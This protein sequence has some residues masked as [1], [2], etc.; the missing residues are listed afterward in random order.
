MDNKFA[1]S[2]DNGKYMDNQSVSGL[3]LDLEKYYNHKQ[4]KSSIKKNLSSI[5]I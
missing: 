2:I 4:Q 5:D 3:I 1:I